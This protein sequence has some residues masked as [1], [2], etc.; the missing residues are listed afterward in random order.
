M[1][2]TS[3]FSPAELI[4]N[5]GKAFAWVSN[6]LK[7]VISARNLHAVERINELRELF[8][9]L[10]EVRQ[11]NLNFSQAVNDEMASLTCVCLDE[12]RTK[13]PNQV[14]EVG[15]VLASIICEEDL[16]LESSKKNRIK[17][18]Y[19]YSDAKQLAITILIRLFSTF[20]EA[21]SSLVP[22]LLSSLI[23]NLIRNLQKDKYIHANYSTS[24][25][26]LIWVIFERFDANAIDDEMIGKVSRMVKTVSA[27]I[28][29]ERN[30]Y[31]IGLIDAFIGCWG[32]IL[33]RKAI[34]DKSGDDVL[35]SFKAKFIND[36]LGHFAFTNSKTRITSARIIAETLLYYEQHGL[37]SQERTWEF[38]IEFFIQSKTLAVKSCCFE[39]ICHFVSLNVLANVKYLSGI[40]YL[41]LF[42][43][44]SFGI[45]SHVDVRNLTLDSI[46]RYLQ[47]FENLHRL[48]FPYIGEASENAILFSIFG[49]K[50][51]KLLQDP[52]NETSFTTIA[53]LQFSK[54]LMEDSSSSFDIDNRQTSIIK[55]K[56]VKLC[57][58]DNFQIRVHS[59]RVLNIFMQLI[60]RFMNS[61]LTQ[62]LDFL[63]A[64]FSSNF[65]FQQS[66]GSAL[67][68][69]S[70]MNVVDPDFV[71]TELV[72]KIMVFALTL[73][74]ASS[75]TSGSLSYY[76]GLISWILLCGLMTYRD[77]NFLKDHTSQML[78]FWKNILTHSFN[79]S[80]EDELYKN[81]ELRSHALTCL[82]A[83]LDAVSAG[84]DFCKEVCFLLS[85]CSAFNHSISLKSKVID[86]ALLG[87]EKRILQL[88]LKIPQ[89]VRGDFNTALLIL[90]VKNFSDPNIYTAFPTSAEGK[91]VG[92]SGNGLSSELVVFDELFSEKSY[93]SCGIT[94]KCHGDQLDEI[95]GKPQM[96]YP[97]NGILDCSETKGFWYD[98][99]EDEISKPI[100]TVLSYDYLIMFYSRR[101]Y[102]KIE[103]FCP[104]VTTSIIDC[105]I[106]IFS[107]TF[108]F[109][110]KKIQHSV[111]ESLNSCIFSKN[112]IN[113][114]TAAITVNTCLAIHGALLILH[115]ENLTLE[116]EIG[117]LM[118]QI[119]K[120][121]SFGEN[122]RLMKLRADA[123][124]LIVTSRLSDREIASGEKY[125]Y[126]HGNIDILQKAIVD[127]PN[128]YERAFN[129]LSIASICK[130][131]NIKS[132]SHSALELFETLS[133]DT[134]PVV[135]TWALYGIEILF[136]SLT[137][138]DLAVAG[139]LLSLLETFIL[140]DQRGI[141]S[142]S[143]WTQNYCTTFN[144]HFVIGN[145]LNGLTEILGPDLVSLDD[146]SRERFR[147]L[148]FLLLSSRN[149][150]NQ[151]VILKICINL[152]TF[153]MLDVVPFE[154]CVLLGRTLIKQ[155]FSC[156]CGAENMPTTSLCVETPLKS[157]NED[158]IKISF[159]FFDQVLKLGQ[160]SSSLKDAAHTVWAYYSMFPR[161]KEGQ[162]Y[163][164][165]WLFETMVEDSTW[166][167]KV[168]A[169]FSVH[170]DELLRY[171]YKPRMIHVIGLSVGAV[172][173]R[174]ENAT[175]FDAFS[176]NAQHKQMNKNISI[177]LDE[178]LR[179]E[180]RVLLMESI[181]KYFDYCTELDNMGP[182]LS[183]KLLI[184]IK[185]SFQAATSN[186]GC[187]RRLGIE[188]LEVIINFYAEN[189][190]DEAALAILNEEKAQVVSSLMSCVGENRVPANFCCAVRVAAKYLS[191]NI[192]SLD[193]MKRVTSFFES[194]LGEFMRGKESNHTPGKV[195][196]LT[197]RAKVE[198]EKSILSA[199]A[200][201][202]LDACRNSSNKSDLLIFVENHWNSLVPLWIIS[203]REHSINCNR[204]KTTQNGFLI[205]NGV[206]FDHDSKENRKR[207]LVVI[208][209]ICCA[210][211]K[212]PKLLSQCL[213]EQDLSAFSF[214]MFA[215]CIQNI[216]SNFE[217]AS[218][219]Q[220]SLSTVGSVLGL[221]VPLHCIFDSEIQDE[222]AQ[223]FD[224]IALTGALKSHFAL[225]D[226]IEKIVTKFFEYEKSGEIGISELDKIYELLRI[227][228]MILG[229]LQPQLKKSVDDHNNL[230]STLSEEH[231][232]LLIKRVFDCFIS[233]VD[234]FPVV[235]KNDLC[236][237]LF[238]TIGEIMYSDGYE[239]L[240]PLTLPLLK[241]IINQTKSFDDGK[242]MV[243]IFYNALK[244][245]IFE[246]MPRQL[247]ITT[248]I[249]LLS[250]YD[251]FDSV[252]I[253][254]IASNLIESFKVEEEEELAFGIMCSTIKNM[255]RSYAEA[256]ILKCFLEKLFKD[257]QTSE[258]S[259]Y[260][261][262]ADLMRLLLE[263][264]GEIDKESVEKR[265]GVINLSVLALAALLEVNPDQ[266]QGFSEVLMEL[267]QIDGEEVKRSIQLH[268]D[269]HEKGLVKGLIKLT[270]GGDSD[271]SERRNQSMKL[272][273]FK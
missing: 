193:E 148:I 226:V 72:M 266:K 230:L 153:K 6:C 32:H 123:I 246:E 215:E 244:S 48:I 140:S 195:D 3:E 146:R 198:I 233:V 68:I 171:C 95:Q 200:E 82:L 94:S 70:L 34:K 254:V 119:L 258:V 232:R 248:A 136:E 180:G 259:S 29:E 243:N 2:Q 264:N 271:V 107:L 211:D 109:L 62:S 99:F 86:S 161:T 60:P 157:Y 98:R 237:C 216:V 17:K 69:S 114:R 143:T 78:I 50:S 101:G 91:A 204:V 30:R 186:V 63:T 58:S 39:S 52:I 54:L 84:D 188:L 18:R 192:V 247:S 66:H 272:K 145:I 108:P 126:M 149:V 212:N 224:R 231:Q 100:T 196:G 176:S 240:V 203:L 268:L 14:W 113:L 181:L 239:K 115:S 1:A 88:Y 138:L 219:T 93:F 55:E 44:L 49:D 129:A 47:Y 9:V 16:N 151:M 267:I 33:R 122:E 150:Q 5:D 137:T 25:S 103:A 225:I 158:A 102:S 105:S 236:A 199:W 234:K 40:R 15:N 221:E 179:W 208:D 67:I 57:L 165:K 190:E 168:C 21:L 45:L 242:D 92:K 184:L 56:L 74:K 83:F 89:Y 131:G 241:Y 206:N 81:L 116:N 249:I 10:L 220:S 162:V 71:S 166:V 183:S 170:F 147:N 41:E 61:T 255:S 65:E 42:E 125:E 19:S 222:L 20:H 124:G 210:N 164:E 261:K 28:A 64:G 152:A 13:D 120:G 185:L 127:I 187:L 104:R 4:E 31:P 111:L 117:G 110:N 205:R 227:V 130:H 189:N 35:N 43:N 133:L 172:D 79:F 8:K 73:N 75:S 177:S 128:P 154:H 155:S 252:E 270:I 169:L 26:Q 38:Y 77:E 178:P 159:T 229:Q 135:H 139:K 121:M 142:A 201:L 106:E 96:I 118:L 51:E 36:N 167:N 132:L 144:P 11:V 197:S 141:F 46:S 22:V 262:P 37:I 245:R 250:E 173:E 112:T 163:L 235:F 228:F 263:L 217:D 238:Y 87:N 257:L 214:V 213:G 174:Q 218:M 160:F 265:T 251:L 269:E 207:W 7:E 253:E 12:L 175:S 256:K 85:K 59:V 209:A 90:I 191:S 76:K 260:V 23:K 80:S 24:I 97:T 194:S 273:T 202:T 182:I 156:F 223:I 53:F 134:H 27:D